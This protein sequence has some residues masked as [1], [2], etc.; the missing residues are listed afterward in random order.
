[1]GDAAVTK[2]G[3]SYLGLMR[4]AEGLRHRRAITLLVGARARV[5]ATCTKVKAIS[6]QRLP[7]V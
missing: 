7:E 1:M 4:A 3:A 2:A 6:A 5:R